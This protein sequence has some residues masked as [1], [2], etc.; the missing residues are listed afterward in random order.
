VPIPGTKRRV[1]VEE[2]A[3]AVDLKLSNDDVARLEAAL[4]LEAVSGSRYNEKSWR[5]LIAE[6]KVTV[7]EPFGGNGDCSP[8]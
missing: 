3:G 2:N 7:A 1:Y 8:A 4:R 6:G 5:G